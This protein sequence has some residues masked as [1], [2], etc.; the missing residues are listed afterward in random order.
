M[1]GTPG[2]LPSL[3]DLGAIGTEADTIVDKLVKERTKYLGR[4]RIQS[5]RS[6][7][8]LQKNKPPDNKI[9]PKVEKQ[10][11]KILELARVNKSQ[12]LELPRIKKSEQ[13]SPP[14]EL[15]CDW[16]FKFKQAEMHF[17]GAKLCTKII[18]KREP[19]K[20]MSSSVTAV[21]EGG[22]RARVAAIWWAV[23]QDSK[24]EAPPRVFRTIDSAVKNMA[25]ALQA[26]IMLNNVTICY[27]RF[28]VVLCL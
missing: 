3:D 21:F 17:K 22:I 15:V 19:H 4:K 8:A 5:C 27:I 12:S 7:G 6:T 14:E 1:F 25:R 24:G 11:S 2:E 18:E 23:T 16:N 13:P 9:S 28:L 20:N 10:H 26:T